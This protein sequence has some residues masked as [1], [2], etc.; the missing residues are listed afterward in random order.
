MIYLQ[1][2]RSLQQ[3]DSPKPTSCRR[4]HLTLYFTPSVPAGTRVQAREVGTTNRRTF[5]MDAAGSQ[6]SLTA[7]DHEWFRQFHSNLGGILSVRVDY[8]GMNWSDRTWCSENT[9]IGLDID[10][11]GAVDRIYGDFFVDIS[12][13]GKVEHLHEWFAPSEGI[14]LHAAMA[15]NDGLISSGHF[16]RTAD[17]TPFQ[18]ATDARELIH[19]SGAVTG[20]HLFGDMGALFDNGFEKLA[21]KDSDHNGVVIGSELGGLAIWVD[22]NSNAKV[23]AGEL[24]SLMSF[25]IVG[26]STIPDEGTFISRAMLADGSTMMMEDLFFA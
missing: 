18:D 2:S 3:N 23:D 5:T 4:K 16:A 9:P 24:N 14:L 6:I 19:N 7:D 12:G 11:N 20:K 17:A 10:G 15:M 21:M 26:L 8:P 25:G 22:S 13:D 1:G